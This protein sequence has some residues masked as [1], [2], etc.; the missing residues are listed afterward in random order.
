M[1]LA[2]TNRQKIEGRKFQQRQYCMSKFETGGCVILR[3]I[4]DP[5]CEDLSNCPTVC[6][7]EL[8]MLAEV[9]SYRETSD[10]ADWFR[11]CH[12]PRGPVF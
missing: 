11:H 2:T 9:F 3:G 1:N 12:V 8:A 7:A 6:L 10:S 4:L 5:I